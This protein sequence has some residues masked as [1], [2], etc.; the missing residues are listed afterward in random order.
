MDLF[1]STCTWFSVDL[2]HFTPI[3]VSLDHRC[4]HFTHTHRSLGGPFEPFDQKILGQWS[5]KLEMRIEFK[6]MQ[7]IPHSPIIFPLSHF[8]LSIYLSLFSL[9]G[10]LTISLFSLS[11]TISLFSLSLFLFSLS[12]YPS[13][14]WSLSLSHYLSFLVFAISLFSL[15]HNLTLDLLLSLYPLQ[16]LFLYPFHSYFNSIHKSSPKP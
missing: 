10:P 4:W 2:F 13:L 6:I 12:H 9:P 3:T 11:L 5:V 7:W 1:G 16:S 14:L 8:S 15:S